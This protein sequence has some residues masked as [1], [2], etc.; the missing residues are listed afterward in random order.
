MNRIGRLSV[1]V[2]LAFAA[3]AVAQ[4][5]KS[6]LIPRDLLFGNPDRAAV[7]LSHDGKYLSYLAPSNG[8]LNVWIAPIDDLAKAKAITND[9]KRGIQTYEWAYTN[10][11]ILYLQDEGGDENWNIH[12]VDISNGKD[13]NLTPD[14]KVAARLEHISPKFPDEIL[15]QLNDR[16]PQFQIG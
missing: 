3:L 6:D 15:V 10:Q 1:L 7:R 4:D 9:S 13:T 11:H 5:S 14:K 12:C 2:L 16:V 8:V